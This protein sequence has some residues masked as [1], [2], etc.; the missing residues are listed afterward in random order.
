MK[1]FMTNYSK[2]DARKRSP[3]N[4][5]PVLTNYF[6]LGTCFYQGSTVTKIIPQ[7]SLQMEGGS[8]GTVS[9]NFH[10]G[11]PALERLEYHHY[12]SQ[13][14]DPPWSPPPPP[15]TMGDTCHSDWISGGKTKRLVGITEQYKTVKRLLQQLLWHCYK[16]TLWTWKLPDN[17]S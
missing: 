12:G 17:V 5:T 10:C 2:M 7:C 15:P 13:I 8:L 16:T 6:S 3:I 1:F 11:Q 4:C 14:L 9:R